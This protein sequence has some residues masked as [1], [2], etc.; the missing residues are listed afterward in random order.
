[1]RTGRIV[2][3]TQAGIA[4]GRCKL[5]LP[6]SH[7]ALHLTPIQQFSPY[8]LPQIS[9]T[10]L[11]RSQPFLTMTF[12]VSWRPLLP[13]Q[14][15]TD[16][17]MGYWLSPASSHVMKLFLK[18]SEKVT[19]QP[20]RVD[21]YYQQRAP[22]SQKRWLGDGGNDIRNDITPVSSFQDSTPGQLY[23]YLTI[24]FSPNLSFCHYY[25]VPRVSGSL[26]YIV[27]PGFLLT[28]DVLV[29]SDLNFVL[30]KFLFLIF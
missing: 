27:K 28:K 8:C 1:M 15:G 3:I 22:W 21:G 18:V 14:A 10:W 17:T 9:L 6:P 30:V 23:F 16:P 20:L 24:H 5:S 26:F 25:P 11:S 19:G 29:V 2:G 4:T 7:T 13:S 12:L